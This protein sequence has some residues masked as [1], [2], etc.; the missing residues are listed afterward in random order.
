MP[1][2]RLLVA[3]VLGLVTTASACPPVLLP[4]TY[5]TG[6]TPYKPW[7]NAAGV[8]ENSKVLCTWTGSATMTCFGRVPTLGA[9]RVW[10]SGDFGHTFQWVGE[11]A[12]VSR[13]FTP[14]SMIRIV[15]ANGRPGY[16]VAADSAGSL[17]PG[18]PPGVGVFWTT[19]DGITFAASTTQSGTIQGSGVPHGLAQGSTKRILAMSALTTPTQA[20]TCNDGISAG[21]TWTC[22]AN[23]GPTGGGF[24][25]IFVG[26][27][28]FANVHGSTWIAGGYTADSNVATVFRSTDD[29]ATWVSV[30]EE[31]IDSQ[32]H[33][34]ACLTNSSI[35]FA[36]GTK[37]W[38]SG[39]AGVTWT[40]LADSAG[41]TFE[42]IAVFSGLAATMVPFDSTASPSLS[43]TLDGGQT[44]ATLK[45]VPDQVCPDITGINKSMATVAVHDGR[46]LVVTHYS[47]IINGTCAQYS[48]WSL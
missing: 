16:L 47:N 11:S 22:S 40:R 34:T 36:V 33:A 35:C 43:Q 25:P 12:Q 13:N 37:I 9:N 14:Q 48:N 28:V 15:L 29:G 46:A 32:I 5:V 45:F 41:T 17:N 26:N 44:W 18:D 4:W 19:E 42:G 2:K 10:H 1:V 20:W 3:L 27:Q 24:W 8:P 30:F 21:V 23:I 39:D 6:A 38:R 7:V 31:T